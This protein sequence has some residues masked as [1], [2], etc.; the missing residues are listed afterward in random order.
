[1]LRMISYRIPHITKLLLLYT[2]DDQT[3]ALN[4]DKSVEGCDHW[5][6]QTI[7]WI[8]SKNLSA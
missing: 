8:L 6:G 2:V 3:T 4:H 5:S 1:M 7:L